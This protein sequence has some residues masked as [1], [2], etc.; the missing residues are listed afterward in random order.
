[1]ILG[2]PPLALLP[3]IGFFLQRGLSRSGGTILAAIDAGGTLV[4][5]R[6]DRSG[7]FGDGALGDESADSAFIADGLTLLDVWV[8]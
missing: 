4:H 6:P 5:R 3:G 2:L 1:M 8:N 7:A